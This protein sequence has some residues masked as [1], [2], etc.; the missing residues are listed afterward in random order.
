MNFRRFSVFLLQA[1][2][3]SLMPTAALANISDTTTFTGSVPGSCT[4]SSGTSQTVTMSYSTSNNGTF[5]GTSEN[6]G[7][8]CNFATSVTLG[9]VTADS[10]NPT[11]TSNTAT[12]T[13]NGSTVVTSGSSPSAE[14]ALNNTPG[15]PANVTISLEAQNANTVG[16]YSYTV[17][18]TTLST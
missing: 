18:L 16:A 2:G 14:T 5:T 13:F 9:A 17:T 4:Y 11:E 15:S 8:S 1:V 6:I 12:L 7:I 10:G 3:F